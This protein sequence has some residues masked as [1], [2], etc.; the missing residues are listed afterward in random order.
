MEEFSGEGWFN[1]S[2][3]KKHLSWF[4]T[5]AKWI[6]GTLKVDLMTQGLFKTK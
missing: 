2:L 5:S 4:D 3:F 6:C 1:T